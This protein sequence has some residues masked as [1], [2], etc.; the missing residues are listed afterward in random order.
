MS[1][2]VGRM[3]KVVL[4]TAR[5]AGAEGARLSRRR[6][7]GGPRLPIYPCDT[8]AAM[9]DEVCDR[10]GDT[11]RVV[12]AYAGWSR[13]LP[14]LGASLAHLDDP[15]EVACWRQGRPSRASVG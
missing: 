3:F 5:N 13:A 8:C 2:V 11:A 1:T 15:L 9:T 7:R 4:D 10:I 6:D 12:D 14:E